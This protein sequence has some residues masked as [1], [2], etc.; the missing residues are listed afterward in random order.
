[1][2]N[3]QVF[4]NPDFGEI[5][6]ILLDNEP[7]FVGNDVAKALGYAKPQSA[8]ASNVEEDDTLKQGVTDSLGRI[9]ETTIINESG[10]YC[11]IFSSKLPKAKEFKHWVT[12]EVLPSIRKSGTYSIPTVT[13]NI[14]SLSGFASTV[15]TLRRIMRDEGS[16]ATEIARM[17]EGLCRQFGIHVPDNFVKEVPGQLTL[18]GREQLTIGGSAQ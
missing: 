2:N 15:N 5:R 7:W 12:S 10:L 13:P 9:Q 16:T 8:I 6:S 18:F 11:L 1:M 3:L 17:A 4:N 14:M